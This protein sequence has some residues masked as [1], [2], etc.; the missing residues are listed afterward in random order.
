MNE[1]RKLTKIEDSKNTEKSNK[2]NGLNLKQIVKIN[3]LNS[4]FTYT[5]NIV[6]KSKYSKNI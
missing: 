4:K 6:N 2:E 3:T 5:K 1:K